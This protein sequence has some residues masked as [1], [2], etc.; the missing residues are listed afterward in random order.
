MI[1]LSERQKKIVAA[2]LTVTCL[3]VTFAF[4]AGV[5]WCLV[6]F[7]SFASAAIVPVVLGFL[8]ALFFK[9]YY[10]WWRE[11]VRNPTL[12][13]MA[14]LTTV[15]VPLVTVFW[16][17]TALLVGQISNLIENGPQLFAKV[18]VWFSTT[19]P[20]I[21]GLLDRLGL[22]DFDLAD[23]YARYGQTAFQA[24]VGILSCLTGVLSVLVTFV[25]FVFFL[26]T[27][28]RRGGDIVAA[29]PFLKKETRSF[30][31][32]Q[33]DAFIDILVSFFQRQVLICLIEGVFYGVGFWLVGLH[34]GFLL[35]FVLGVLNLVPFFGSIVC[36]PFALLLAHFQPDGSLLRLLLV[37]AVWGSGQA[38]DG[39]LIT[40]KIQ[41][42][43]TGLG[44]GG[45]IFSFFFWSTVL[46]PVRG[47]L[48]AIPL[49]AFCVVL[50]R[51][52]KATYFRS[53]D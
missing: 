7:L 44:Y 15:F 43:R 26:T 52:V 39:Y 4:A 10:R 33:I 14:M 53:V 48:L 27:K 6:K 21:S 3:A 23:L 18:S 29:L 5:V 25:F 24:G 31:A 16:F 35:G 20:T 46:G 19:Y 11:T 32:S 36:L 42:N 49:S 17:I 9:P 45:V 1:E 34:Y 41:G 38:L 13:L 12:A 2:G 22:V 28:D 51:A 30:L 50:A 37:L 47:M 8:L 40:P